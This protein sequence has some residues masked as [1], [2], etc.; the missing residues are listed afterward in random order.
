MKEEE[1]THWHWHATCSK[2]LGTDKRVGVYID[3]I[4]KLIWGGIDTPMIALCLSNTNQYSTFF[5][6]ALP[7]ICADILAVHAMLL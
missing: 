5:P 1:I 4:C 2:T 3:H 6:D 7:D